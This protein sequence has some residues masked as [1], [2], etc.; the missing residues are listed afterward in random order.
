M[1]LGDRFWA[2]LISTDFVRWVIGIRDGYR[3]RLNAVGQGWYETVGSLFTAGQ[4]GQAFLVTLAAIVYVLIGAASFAPQRLV[5]HSKEITDEANAFA[6]D[7][8]GYMRQKLQQAASAEGISDFAELFGTFLLDPALSYLERYAGDANP[9]PKAFARGIMGLPAALAF[10]GGVVDGTLQGLLGDRAPQVG[11][12]LELTINGM[13]FDHVGR[14]ALTPILNAG[15]WPNFERYYARLYRPARFTPSQVQDLYALGELTGVAFDEALRDQGWREGDIAAY[16][17]L[18]YKQLSEGDAW[19]LYHDGVIDKGEMDRRLRAL[20]YNSADFELL[21]KANPAEDEAAVKGYTIST[22]KSAFQSGLMDESEF[23]SIMAALKYQS[24]EIDLQVALIRAKQT[25]D[26]RDLTTGQIKELYN[27]RIIGRDEAATN[28]RQLTYAPAVAAQL[29]A[30]WDNEALPKAIRLNKSTILQAFTEGVYTRRQAVQALQDEAGYDATR[31][32][33]LVRVEEAQIKRQASAGVVKPATL[34][35]LQEFV[36][37]GLITRAELESRPELQKYDDAT[38]ALQIDLLYLK[39]QVAPVTAQVSLST[40][41]DAY[42]FGLFTRADYIAR[43][44]A[45]NYSADDAA[46]QADVTEA[47]N[48][49]AFGAAEEQP[50]KAPSVASLQLALQRGLIDEDGFR[51]RL[52]AQGYTDEAVTIASF[53]AQYQAPANPK[54][55]TQSQVISLYKSTDITRADA[56]RRLLGLGYT[57]PDVELLIKQV[58]LAPDDTDAAAYYLAGL[59]SEDGLIVA[60]DAEGFTTDE[61]ADFLD[62]AAAGLIV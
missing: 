6:E 22:L 1:G 61:I 17:R 51:A 26:A 8:T 34:S 20:G 29:I 40:L 52:A 25:Q 28:L 43:L 41:S 11:R 5:P 16:R 54:S 55:L 9:D 18:A 49:E 31:A 38:R 32:E 48:P 27:Q 56:T 58:R 47:A 14:A 37:Y 53:N 3:Q 50:V 36:Q 15:L 62:R 57:A 35:Q 30:A 24:R 21:Y 4:I 19:A 7:P 46:L 12:A 10:A 2:W 23:R 59:L 39:T 13:G 60:L 45:R 42:V 44:E 33:L